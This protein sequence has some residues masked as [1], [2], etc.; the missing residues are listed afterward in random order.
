VLSIAGCWRLSR[1]DRRAE[2]VFAVVCGQCPE[3]RVRR[4][5]DPGEDI[6]RL[7]K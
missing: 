1:L 4:A 2:A 6:D 5:R 3:L 7:T